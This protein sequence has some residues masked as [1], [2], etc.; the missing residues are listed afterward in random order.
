MKAAVSWSGGKDSALSC[1]KAIKSGFSVTNL[2]N[3][4]N[5]RSLSHGS[6]EMMALQSDAI[7]IPIVQKETCWNDYERDFKQVLRELKKNGVTH[8][9]FGD[10]DLQEHK[11]W[12]DRVCKECDLI[13]VSPLWKMKRGEV[14]REFIDAGF[15]AIIVCTKAEML[16]ETWL[17]RRLDKKFMQDM[18]K[19][20]PDVDLCGESGE[21]HTFVMNGPIFKKPV[22]IVEKKK[23]MR[24]GYWY[25][26]ISAQR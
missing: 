18:Q 12:T 5:E 10:I 14:M 17:G 21:Y 19:M 6:P 7:G 26:E 15:E 22:G 11:D 9:I 4:A 25:L 13:P 23:F 16:D 8:A 3:M 20:K 1:Y 2:I 24:G